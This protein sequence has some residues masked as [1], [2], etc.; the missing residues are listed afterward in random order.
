M[1]EPQWE[2]IRVTNEI[3]NDLGNNFKDVIKR[4][5]VREITR[6][7]YDSD[8]IQVEEINDPQQGTT[9]INMEIKVKKI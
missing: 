7:L 6:V 2:T 1:V 3:T 9:K 8:L 5:M 4:E